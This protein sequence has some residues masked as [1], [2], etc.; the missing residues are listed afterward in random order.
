MQNKDPKEVVVDKL[1]PVGFRVLLKIYEK[2]TET[3]SGFILPESE[4]TGMPVMGQITVLGK[5]TLW[6]KIL[7]LFGFRPRYRIGQW[8][9]FRKYS[10][11]ELIINAPEGTLNLFVLEENEIIGIIN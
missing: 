7:I 10:V 8:I 9:Y 6:E 3:D 1:I 2:P 11:D 5:K 4:H